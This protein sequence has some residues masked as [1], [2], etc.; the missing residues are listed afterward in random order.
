MNDGNKEKIKFSISKNGKVQD[1]KCLICNSMQCGGSMASHLKNQHGEPKIYGK[2]Y[3]V[4]DE[5]GQVIPKNTRRKSTKSNKNNY[6]IEQVRC[7]LCDFE[8][9]AKSIGYHLTKHHNCG[10][11]Q[12]ENYEIISGGIKK[13][14]KSQNVKKP[15]QNHNFMELRIPVTLVIPLVCGNVKIEQ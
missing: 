11:I 4:L 9:S 12:G 2:T 14:K 7:L 8:T 5:Y 3:V 15:L 1:T 6:G 13:Q 10:Q